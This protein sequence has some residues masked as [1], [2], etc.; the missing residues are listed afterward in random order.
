MLPI[1]IC[2]DGFI[3]SHAVENITLMETEDVKKFVGTYEPEHFLLNPEEPM[4]VGPYA[5]SNYCMEAK[6]AK[7][8]AMMNAK[9]VI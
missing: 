4:A 9:Q 8:Q 3:T 2:Q 1:M 6:R 7:A 5:V